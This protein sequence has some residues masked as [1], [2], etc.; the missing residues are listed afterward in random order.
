MNLLA[1]SVFQQIG[2]SVTREYYVNDS[3]SQIQILTN[4]LFKRYSQ[5]LGYK[6]ELKE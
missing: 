4:S 3:G 2:Y 5:L 1:R 6:V